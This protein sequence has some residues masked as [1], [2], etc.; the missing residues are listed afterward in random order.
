[1]SQFCTNCNRRTRFK[2]D[3]GWG[4]FLMIILTCGL[5]MFVIMFYPT[6][7]L[8][9]GTSRTEVVLGETPPWVT[10]MACVVVVAIILILVRL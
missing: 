3:L 2:K 7:C 9:C 4:T 6:R 8:I 1:M 5:W 10:A